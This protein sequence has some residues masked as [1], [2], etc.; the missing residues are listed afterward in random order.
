MYGLYNFAKQTVLYM[1]AK[2]EPNL[3]FPDK[4]V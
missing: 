2:F 1:H 4:V 3:S